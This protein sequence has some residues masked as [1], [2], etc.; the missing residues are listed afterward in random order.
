MKTDD[1][2]KE[3]LFSAIDDINQLL[4]E[5]QRLEKNLNAFVYGDVGK[6]DSLGLVNL[7]VA[8][9]KKIEDD[10]GI[11]I[12]LADDKAMSKKNSPF[13]TVGTLVNYISVLLEEKSNGES[14]I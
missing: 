13:R 14:E 1:K 3:A 7:I 5:E 8:V 11:L 6:L 12:T 4:S 9:E 10:F 2:I